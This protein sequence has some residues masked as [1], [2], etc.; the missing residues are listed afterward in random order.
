MN[1]K[2]IEVL[3][4]NFK[5]E[6]FPYPTREELERLLEA[7]IRN[8]AVQIIPQPDGFGDTVCQIGEYWFYFG[9]YTTGRIS[10]LEY[11]LGTTKKKLVKALADS[12]EGI[13]DDLDDAEYA[14]YVCILRDASE[15]QG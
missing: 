7:G 4:Q 14:Y 6:E 10:P 15:N 8:G 12:L 9:A 11:L 2:E 5:E 1:R 13:R 3:E